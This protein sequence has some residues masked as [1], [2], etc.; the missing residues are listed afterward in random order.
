MARSQGHCRNNNLAPFRIRRSDHGCHAH[1]GMLVEDFLDVVREYVLSSADDHVLL[2]IDDVEI[3][4]LVEPPHIPEREE[5]ATSCSSGRLGIVVVLA[6]D[7]RSTDVDFPHLPLRHGIA[8][9]VAQLNV[10]SNYRTPDR[11]HLAPL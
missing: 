2:A 8:I 6:N 4:F 5:L 11:A 9:V 1:G 10:Q 7:N 3:T